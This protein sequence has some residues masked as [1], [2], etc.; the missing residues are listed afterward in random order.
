MWVGEAAFILRTKQ[1]RGPWDTTESPIS[2][3]LPLLSFIFQPRTRFGQAPPLQSTVTCRSVG[4]PSLIVFLPAT[5]EYN[6][7]LSFFQPLFS[8]CLSCSRCTQTQITTVLSF[9]THT[10]WYVDRFSLLVSNRLS[11][12]SPR[13][14]PRVARVAGHFQSSSHSS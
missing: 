4:T 2:Y 3:S 9:I 7:V 5:C 13:S 14:T 10:H 8:Y 6:L 1:T 12:G 11:I